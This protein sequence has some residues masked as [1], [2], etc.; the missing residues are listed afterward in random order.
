MTTFDAAA[1][2]VDDRE[3]ELSQHFL[4][5]CRGKQLG[6][7]F[8]K[9][10]QC[11]LASECG[12]LVPKNVIYHRGDKF[13]DAEIG[14]PL[15]TK[16][17]VSSQ[18]E[19]GDIH[20]C[21][22]KQ[23]LETALQEESHCQSFLIQEFIEKEYEIDAVGVSTDDGVVFGGAIHKY[24]HWPPLT[25]AGAYGVFE[26]INAFNLDLEGIGR[27]LKH[28]GYHGPFSVEFVH[29]NDKKNYFM[30]V[31]FRNEGLAYA[32]TCAGA[33]LHAL[34]VCSDYRIDWSKFRRIFMMNY[35]IDLLYVKQGMLSRWSWLKDCLRTRCF[36]NMCFSDLGPT[37]AHYKAK[38]QRS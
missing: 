4:T 38:W 13:P 22:S 23:E 31:N 28:S 19:K 36:I 33:N 5:P 7:L 3:A 25:G 1:Q 32:S 30:E 15:I 21:R 34:Y 14:Y 26:K 24:R 8:D 18:G 17:L 6:R 35:S 2:W 16:P 9:A 12:L 10:E 20:I 11:T 29:T 37:I 27:F